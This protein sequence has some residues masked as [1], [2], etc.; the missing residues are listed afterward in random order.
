MLNYLTVKFKYECNMTKQQY[1]EQLF[2]TMLQL[3]KLIEGQAHDSNEE[4]KTTL[5]QFYALKYLKANNN[6]TVG[7]LANTTTEE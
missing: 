4:K 2:K 3:R 6:S 5:M 7:D 1:I